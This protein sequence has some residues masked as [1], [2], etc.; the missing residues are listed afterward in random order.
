[1]ATEGT[2]LFFATA[3]ETLTGVDGASNPDV[4]HDAFNE[5]A[6]LTAS[7][8]VP[9]TKIIEKVITLTAGAYTLDL[10]TETGTNGVAVNGTGLKIRLLRM[11][12]LGAN[13]FSV[14]TGASNG[15]T[16][17]SR[18]AYVGGVDMAYFANALGAIGG[19]AKTLD[20]TGTG[21]QTCEVTIWMG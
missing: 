8:T 17:G 13:N 3:T 9:F 20:F 10:T 18:T 6:R 7:S 19:S 4:V 16:I 14:A 12:P 11:K 1:M 2:Y 21:S 15:Y 5:T